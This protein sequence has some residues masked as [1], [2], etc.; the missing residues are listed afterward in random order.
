MSTPVDT[1]NIILKL[2]EL[3]REETMR[4]ARDF[5]LGF[6]PKSFADIQAVFMSPEGSYFRMVTSYWEM[7]ASFVTSGAVDATTFDESQGE[8]ILVFCKVEPFLAELRAMFASPNYMKNLEKVCTEAPG[9][10][11]RV[12][13]TRERIRG[14]LAARAAAA[15][16]A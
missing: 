13:A 15:A 5:M 1:A 2:Y 8:H 10:L 12:K 3:R 6:D 7:A 11:E 16:K 14:M 9:G 4:K